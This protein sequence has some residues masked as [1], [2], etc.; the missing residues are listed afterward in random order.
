M[1]I[2]ELVKQ[3]YEQAVKSGWHEDERSPL[4]YHA[5]IH[6]EIAE[7]TEEARKP[8]LNMDGKG[9]YGVRD[10][11][12]VDYK[13]LHG[14]TGLKPEGELIELAD[15]IIRIADYCGSKG[16]DLEE[17]IKLKMEYNKTRSHRHGGKKY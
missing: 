12:M 8:Y 11:K 6:S 14:N 7:A 2:T 15:A 9:V 1:T 16:W 10:D 3:A 5:L 13:V 17:A 4:E